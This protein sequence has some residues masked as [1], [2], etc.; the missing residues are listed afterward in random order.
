MPTP[1]VYDKEDGNGK[2]KMSDESQALHLMALAK[3]VETILS[4]EGDAYARVES[5]DHIET[6][7]WDTFG[8]WLRRTY[9]E[10]EKSPANSSTVK[11][12]LDT[13]KSIAIAAPRR[14]VFTRIGWLDGKLYLDLADEHWQAIEVSASGWHVV[15]KCPV[16]FRR[17]EGML[18]LP[19]PTLGGSIEDLK[20]FL[21]L[22][23][24]RHIDGVGEVHDDW[25]LLIGWILG[26]F[27]PN[28]PHPVLALHGERGTGKSVITKI[29]RRLLDPAKAPATGKPRE[30]RD[31]MIAAKN[32]YTLCFD[33]LSDMP[34]WLSDAFCTLSTGTGGMR[35]RTN[36]SDD[37]ETI[38]HAHRPILLN[39]IEELATAGD[40]LDRSIVITL[41]EF[42]EKTR[43]SEEKL[44]ADFDAVMPGILG[45]ILTLVS[46]ALDARNTV[47]EEGTARMR[48]FEMWV[49]SVETSLG[50][51]SGMFGIVYSL[52]RDAST[53]VEIGAFPAMSLLLN[54]LEDEYLHKPWEGTMEALRLLLVSRA[55]N[56]M[57]RA[58]A[59]PQTA[60]QLQGQLKRCM[61]AMRKKGWE[62]QVQKD[63]NKG[64]VY[65]LRNKKKTPLLLPK[66]VPEKQTEITFPGDDLVPLYP[67]EMGALCSIL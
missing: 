40:L 46:H 67:K 38:F 24:P 1:V 55:E 43:Q 51:P 35:I 2:K 17:T 58:K 59:W 47:I 19:I 8:H 20:P 44:Y 45:A 50:W 57:Q 62:M 48:D 49:T 66:A 11:N 15:N 33:N 53:D 26:A 52:N 6:L 56:G 64:K 30:P 54:L 12:V 27:L 28:G 16:A 63:T 5:G 23:P 41:P 9:Y 65:E 25:I 37:K 32:S 18:P 4:R 39:G 13:L 21:H 3:T 34:Q 22:K 61:P 10:A 14:E 60:Q 7:N 31:L 36:Y 29:L 42:D